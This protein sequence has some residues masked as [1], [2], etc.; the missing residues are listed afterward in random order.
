MQD[1]EELKR[2]KKIILEALAKTLKELRGEQSQFM[3]SSENDI[4]IDI[5]SKSERGIKDPQLTTLYRIAEAF[6]L[7]FSELAHKIEQNLPD[8]FF[9]IE[10]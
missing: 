8:G 2:K 10:K 4:G 7:T 3:F 9:I 1:K 5:V 6:E